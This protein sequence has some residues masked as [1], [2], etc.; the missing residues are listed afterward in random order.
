MKLYCNMANA[1]GEMKPTFQN[2]FSFIWILIC[3]NSAV[4]LTGKKG[5][6]L[7][8]IGRM[9]NN[10]NLT[11]PKHKGKNKFCFQVFSF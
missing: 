11:N 6:L 7:A 1:E 2:A 5:T 3:D 9:K 8:V 10:T 4:C